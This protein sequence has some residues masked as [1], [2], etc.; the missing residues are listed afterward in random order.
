MPLTCLTHD[1]SQS[2]LA[3]YSMHHQ[4]HWDANWQ[5]WLLDNNSIIHYW[6]WGDRRGRDRLVFRFTTTHAIYTDHH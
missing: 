5:A 6:I 2:N 3:R 1:L 4:F